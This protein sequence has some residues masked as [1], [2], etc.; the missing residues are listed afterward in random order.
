VSTLSRI[1]RAAAVGALALLLTAPPALADDTGTPEPTV[2]PTVPPTVQPTAEPTAPTATAA[3]TEPTPTTA[4]TTQAATP[5]SEPEAGS[6]TEPGARPTSEPRAE[7]TTKPSTASTSTK[8][9]AA[10]A[11]CTGTVA[12]SLPTSSASLGGTITVEGSGWCHPAGGGSVIGLKIDAGAISHLDTSVHANKTIWAIVDAEADG[13]FSAQIQLPDGTAATSAPAL[14]TGQHTFTLLSGSLKSGDAARSLQTQPFTVLAAGTDPDDPDAWGVRLA[15][16]D[17]AKAWVQRDVASADGTLRIAGTGWRTTTGAASTIAVKLSSS[18]TQQYRRTSGIIEGDDTIWA[19]LRPG[20]TV[21]ADGS[22]DVKLDLPPALTQGQYLSAR[23]ASGKFG[24]GDVQRSL[25]TAPLSVDGVAYSAPD[26]GADVTCVPT[27]KT[28]TVTVRTPTVALGGSVEVTG[29][30]WCHPTGGG[31]RIG[32]K[33][34]DGAISHL[35]ASLHSNRTIWAIVQADH[36]TGTFTASITLPD[37]TSRTSTP[38]LRNGA[39]TLRFLSGSLRSNDTVRSLTTEF[40]VGVYRPNTT[41]DPLANSDLRKATRGG[42][43]ARVSHGRVHVTLPGAGADDWVFLSAYAADGS[44]RYPWSDRWFRTDA[45]GRII[46]KIGKHAPTGRL[47]LVAQ[48]GQQGHVGELLGWTR[49][50]LRTVPSPVVT[51]TPAAVAAP[52][53]LPV[54]S[55]VVPELPAPSYDALGRLDA[56]GVTA[57]TTGTI[58]TLT[59]PEATPGSTVFVTVFARR[60]VLPAGWISLDEARAARVDLRR[61]G[62]GDFRLALQAADGSLLGWANAPI[63]MAVN[64]SIEVPATAEPVPADGEQPPATTTTRIRTASAAPL[65]GPADGWLAALGVLVLAGTALF[66]RTRKGA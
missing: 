62:D 20:A 21:A 18:D 23:L 17:G 32:V 35:D 2:Q 14:D 41:P 3:P 4:P 22:F 33:I 27:S 51:R 46:A 38:V 42:M 52:A 31:S 40:V 60:R 28:A 9:A 7:P 64:A 48:S 34:D 58:V 30:G 36:H 5:T 54:P 43:T 12:V 10:S 63:E 61:L 45:R 59:V 26:D 44:P 29:T 19:M 47:R 24:I 13:T 8:G 1:G 15:S 49:T 6:E 11:T 37:G 66:L 50:T 56:R 55:L 65:V 25:A 16:A 57:S 53:V 39:H